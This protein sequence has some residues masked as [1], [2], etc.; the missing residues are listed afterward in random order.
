MSGT[1]VV[2]GNPSADVQIRALGAEFNRLVGDVENLRRQVSYMMP[3][4]VL[5]APASKA[6]TT[7]NLKWRTEAFTF[8]F[9]GLIVS[10]AAQEKAF[11]GTTH[12]VAASKEAWMVLTLQTDGTSFTITKG[13]DQ[14]I[15]T[16]VLPT[17]PDNQVIIGY[18]QVVTGATGWVA[19]T[20]ALVADG[21]KI[22]SF[23]FTDAPAMAAAGLTGARVTLVG[24]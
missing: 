3:G 9:R 24:V 10:S 23:A 2:V 20:D 4:V 7:S 12:D 15:G 11:T 16:V 17:G 21:P 18:L 22:T 8:T 5:T 6:G 13:A 19:N 14:T 1:T